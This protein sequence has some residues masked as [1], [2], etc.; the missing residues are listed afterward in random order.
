MGAW[1]RLAASGREFGAG[2]D[3]ELAK[4]DPRRMV[5]SAYISNVLETKNM[6]EDSFDKGDT[7][8]ELWQHITRCFLEL[9]N[10][11]VPWYLQRRRA[12]RT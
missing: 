5:Y 12:D 2:G 7:P 6:R 10:G 8:H 1:E 9:G 4:L 11:I 3:Q